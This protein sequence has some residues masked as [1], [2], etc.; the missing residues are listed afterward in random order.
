MEIADIFFRIEKI[1][2]DSIKLRK[3]REYKFLKGVLQN[4]INKINK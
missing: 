3:R 2:T 1:A 4:K